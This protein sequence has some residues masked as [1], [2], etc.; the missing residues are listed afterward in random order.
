MLTVGRGPCTGRARL[1]L[2]THIFI[3]IH[4]YIYTNLLLT[5]YYLLITYYLLLTTHLPEGVG[6]P[7]ECECRVQSVGDQLLWCRLC[8]SRAHTQSH[9]SDDT[10]HGSRGGAKA[11]SQ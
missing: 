2:A 9:T 7:R 8:R 3:H 5:T 10:V 1:L 4:I 11:A 6:V